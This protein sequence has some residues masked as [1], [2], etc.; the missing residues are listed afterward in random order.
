MMTNIIFRHFVAS[1]FLA[2]TVL[3][4]SFVGF[5]VQAQN[6]Q[7]Q[8]PTQPNFIQTWQQATQKTPYGEVRYGV[9]TRSDAQGKTEKYALTVAQK[10]QAKKTQEELQ[11]EKRFQSFIET[12]KYLAEIQKQQALS[13]TKWQSVKETT[14]RFPIETGTFFIAIGS[15]IAA[16]MMWNY[17][18]DP[19]AMQRHFDSLQDPAAH[20]SFYSFMTANGLTNNALQKYG[21]KKLDEVQKQKLFRRMPYIGMSAGSIASHL[22]GDIYSYLKSCATELLSHTAPSEKPAEVLYSACEEA[23]RL[24]TTEK[25]F[26]Q[27]M[28]ALISLFSSQYLSE[29][30]MRHLMGTSQKVNTLV[31]THLSF[32][33]SKSIG[34]KILVGGMRIFGN[35]ILF[36][37][38]E[39]LVTG[40]I[41]TRGWS[42]ISDDMALTRLSKS[43]PENIQKC[44]LNNDACL[45]LQKDLV[46]WRDR[47]KSWRNTLNAE[48]ETALFSWTELMNRIDRQTVFT[49]SLYANL[50]HKRLED[51]KEK[52]ACAEDQKSKECLKARYA[53]SSSVLSKPQPLYGVLIDS[54]S[55]DSE[56]EL[57]AAEVLK[58]SNDAYLDFYRQNE[59]GQKKHLK[60]VAEAFE[61]FASNNSKFFQSKDE[62]L[63]VSEILESLKSDDTQMNARGLMKLNSTLLDYKKLYTEN[64][65]LWTALKQMQTIIGKSNPITTPYTGFPYIFAI[66]SDNAAAAAVINFPLSNHRYPYVFPTSAHYVI[67]EMMCAN[68]KAQIDHLMGFKTVDQSLV[69][70]RLIQMDSKNLSHFCR[71]M[72]QPNQTDYAQRM[73][74]KF[75]FPQAE[76]YPLEFLIQNINPEAL[77]FE[78]WWLEKTEPSLKEFEDS[79]RVEWAKIYGNL[80]AGFNDNAYAQN[81][82]KRESVSEKIKG[83]LSDRS[84]QSKNA[85]EIINQELALYTKVFSILKNSNA[86]TAFKKFKESVDT[87]MLNI[88]LMSAQPEK[89]KLLRNDLE[90][91]LTELKKTL[92]PQVENTQTALIT[93]TLFY[94][95]DSVFEDITKYLLAGYTIDQNKLKD[96]KDLAEQ[97]K[98][99]KQSSGQ[100]KGSS[101]LFGGKK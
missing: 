46:A 80:I 70:P 8:Q 2:L 60:K 92:Q 68:E 99:L 12:Q 54:Q 3:I 101:G 15:I 51:M 88:K 19:L 24:W 34:G 90:S 41:A 30:T 77:N 36:M 11:N 100:Q 95:L 65:D 23:Q 58:R 7:A 57:P 40:P 97:Q 9:L 1:Y 33:I 63:H 94:G 55:L 28:P 37:G 14:V 67:H 21:Y 86:A 4:T 26:D 38:L 71:P 74:R 91:S 75:P 49:Q 6:S 47:N 96:I 50:I 31:L 62:S 5:S 79:A 78:K 76:M 42:S 89:I 17:G 81:A 69:P 56:K 64:R 16:E 43:I 87:A 82:E 84:G 10:G 25:K 83:F 61:K 85:L 66:N 27:Y 98:K 93:K 18:G 52:Q 53:N 29:L 39:M 44:D 22:T 59:D 45:T 32:D 13:K 35:P 72:L 48:F 20:L 73:M